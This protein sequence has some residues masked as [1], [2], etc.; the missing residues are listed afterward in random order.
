MQ[1]RSFIGTLAGGLFALSSSA[2][3]QSGR[4][5]RIGVLFA[6]PE[7]DRQAQS[8]LA[9]FRG[10]LQKLGWAEIT[11]DTRYVASNDADPMR[12]RTESHCRL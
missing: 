3:S 9:V 11:I 12:D 7:S 5:R 8:R 2:L 4:T 10:E 6:L 1:R